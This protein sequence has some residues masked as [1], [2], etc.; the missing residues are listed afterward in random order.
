M[1]AFWY[2]EEGRA[3]EAIKRSVSHVKPKH[4]YMVLYERV[5][6][7]GKRP[8]RS[9]AGRQ[10]SGLPR[11]GNAGKRKQQGAESAPRSGQE[12]FQGVPG[13]WTA[14]RRELKRYPSWVDAL[15]IKNMRQRRIEG[16]VERAV[17]AF[18]RENG[19]EGG[20]DALMNVVMEAWEAEA[21][22]RDRFAFFTACSMRTL[23]RISSQSENTDLASLCREVYGECLVDA[24]LQV[25]G[26][27]E[28]RAIFAEILGDIG[29]IDEK[30][31][32]VVKSV[33]EEL[34]R[35]YGVMVTDVLTEFLKG[36]EDVG[37]LPK[38]KAVLQLKARALD[39]K[40]QKDKSC[41]VRITA[42]VEC[43]AKHEGIRSYVS[44]LTMAGETLREE[45]AS[46][47]RE[48]QRSSAAADADLTGTGS[49]GSLG[50][51]A[52]ALEILDLVEEDTD[53]EAAGVAAGPG[54]SASVGEEGHG[55]SD[56]PESPNRSQGLEGV[57]AVPS[58]GRGRKR[59]RAPAASADVAPVRRSARLAARTNQA[60][61]PANLDLQVPS[62]RRRK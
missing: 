6:K 56:T 29:E 59:V 21:D 34:A 9:T 48:Q 35:E 53:G 7:W 37:S 61:G 44:F 26:S 28:R 11:G 19:V 52:A 60:D 17:D 39:R 16:L 43:A 41:E 46:I 47:E 1:D 14:P 18:F 4:V 3:P 36:G 22:N 40:Y 20:R 15:Q 24:R 33:D 5:V 58:E 30:E 42:L 62:K 50:T 13:M 54:T 27:A 32:D 38:L 55:Q 45:A 51:G 57:H 2:F 10:G 25:E 23:K 12:E 8:K 31:D 49:S